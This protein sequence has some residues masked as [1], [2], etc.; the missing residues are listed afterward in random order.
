[1]ANTTYD[2][3]A[4][5]TLGSAAASITFSSI[6]TSWTDLRLVLVPTT[7]SA[8]SA[9][10][11]FNGDNASTNY[12]GTTLYG[13]G[14]VSSWNSPA[15]QAKINLTWDDNT[16]TTNPSL[17]TMDI[18]SY[19]GSSYKTCLTTSSNDNNGGGYVT[20]QAWI[21]RNTSAITSIVIYTNAANTYKTGTTAQLYG[22]KAA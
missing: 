7:T 9:Y 10:V 22:I 4:S 20:R 8:G 14:S 15:N 16:Y 1:M 6:A 12:F 5:Q 19:T 21:W 2:L 18:M 17:R 11:A 3:I 13:D